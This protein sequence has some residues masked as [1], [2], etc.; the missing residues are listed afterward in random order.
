VVAWGWFVDKG[1]A[2]KRKEGAR[3]AKAGLILVS[4][5]A[6][7]SSLWLQVAMRRLRRCW[8]QSLTKPVSK[9]NLNRFVSGN[10]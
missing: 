5:G 3:L 9:P 2:D 6:R 10:N 8:L 7:I 1:V 4:N